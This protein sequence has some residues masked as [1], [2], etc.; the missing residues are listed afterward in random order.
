MLSAFGVLARFKGL[1]G[2]FLDPFSYSEHRRLERRLIADYRQTVESLLPTLT[3]ENL[4]LA[5]EIAS[6]PERIRGYGVVKERFMAE[7]AE[8]QRELLAGYFGKPGNNGSAD[9]VKIMSVNVG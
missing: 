5:V 9:V 7:A 1:R 3:G 8:Q 2:T 4:A 6:I